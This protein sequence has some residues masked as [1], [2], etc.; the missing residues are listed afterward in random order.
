M[1]HESDATARRYANA[2]FDI[3]VEHDAVEEFYED[4]DAVREVFVESE[5][6]RHLLLHPAIEGTSRRDALDELIER[7]ELDERIR[8]FLFLL[9]DNERIGKLPA[10]A[11]IYQRLLDERADIVRAEITSAVELDDNQTEALQDALSELTDKQVQVTTDVDESLIGGV[12]ARVG[13]RVYDGS[14][15]NQFEQL[16]DN[17]LQEV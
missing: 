5:E 17:I 4:L 2:L 10:I 8:N 16:K 7:W 15:R 12:V 14:I 3:G 1:E 6:F 13:S 9:L 11:S